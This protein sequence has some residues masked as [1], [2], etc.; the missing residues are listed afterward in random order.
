MGGGR[1]PGSVGIGAGGAHAS[2]TP[3]RPPPSVSGRTILAP[4]T[5]ALLHRSPGRA[6][7]PVSSTPAATAPTS[8]TFVP[9]GRVQLPAPL[10]P[11]ALAGVYLAL[12]VQYLDPA[13]G[14]VREVVCSPGIYAN[15]LIDGRVPNAAAGQ[16]LI[17]TATRAARAPGARLAT[18]SGFNGAVRRSF[19]GHGLPDELGL[20][21]S[22]ALSTGIRTPGNI[23]EYCHNLTVAGLGLDCVGFVQAYFRLRHRFTS[24][25]AINNYRVR[26]RARTSLASIQPD[27]VLVW[28]SSDG[29]AAANHIAVVSSR[30]SSNRFRI[31]E[32]TGSFGG[33]PHSYGRGGG[34][35]ASTYEFAPADTS[36]FFAVRRNLEGTSSTS[37]VSVW[38]VDTSGGES[39]ER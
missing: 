18:P 4:S 3:S 32:S 39:A 25:S 26:S 19:R 20:T 6:E 10:T 17:D 15:T 31:A 14:E 36:G 29:R 38:G 1:I 9:T 16:S 5:L 2:M 13:S 12:R 8:R 23:D 24:P 28:E 21:I 7:E 22:L 11:E 30:T 33:P 27:D 37:T 35:S 34:V